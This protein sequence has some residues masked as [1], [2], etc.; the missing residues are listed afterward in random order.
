MTEDRHDDAE[1]RDEPPAEAVPT[2]ASSSTDAVDDATP[3]EGEAAADGAAAESGTADGTDEAER[4]DDAATA[5][6]GEAEPERERASSA[7]AASEPGIAGTDGGGSASSWRRLAV[8]ARTPK[9]TAANLIIAL[10]VGLLGFALIA[11]VHS[12]SSESALANDRPDDL[13]RILSDL[14]A[15]RD[16][17]STEI[18]S[19]QGTVRQL[20]SGAQ[21][22]QA[23][24]DAAAK[25]ADELGILGGTLPAKGPGLTIDLIPGAKQQ[26]SA[27]RVLD[28]VEELRGAGAEAMQIDGTGSSAVRIVA[29][30]YF[31]DAS[32]G[33]DIDGQVI[34]GTL[35]VTVI[36]DPQTMQAALSIAGGVLDSVRNDGGTVQV[37][38]PTTVEVTALYAAAPLRFATPVP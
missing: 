31:A 17:L 11:Q 33:V 29:S 7:A 34:G 2:P 23:A 5:T 20:N 1:R 19:L 35:T 15:R 9:F 16:R 21:S 12:N 28:T 8:A 30:T 36:G 32:G 25:R 6:D 3:V 37:N 24:L 38:T 27:D 13:V 14:D 18:S 4:P 10:L 26:I 22:R